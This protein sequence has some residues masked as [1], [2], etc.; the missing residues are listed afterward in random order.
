MGEN[1]DGTLEKKIK[2]SII[3]TEYKLNTKSMKA[4]NPLYFMAKV[5]ISFF[6]ESSVIS[7]DQ[8]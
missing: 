1:I 3:T 8:D 6:Y 7:C 4:R 2:I 5:L